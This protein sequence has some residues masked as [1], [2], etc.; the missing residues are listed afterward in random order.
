MCSL[1]LLHWFIL[2]L[3]VNIQATHATRSNTRIEQFF[4]FCS[5]I[6]KFV[7][8]MNIIFFSQ[9]QNIFLQHTL[10]SIDNATQWESG[11]SYM[12]CSSVHQFS[13]VRSKHL[14]P[15]SSACMSKLVSVLW[16][17]FSKNCSLP[18][19]CRL[20]ITIGPVPSPKN[21]RWYAS[22]T[23]EKAEIQSIQTRTY[24][25]SGTRAER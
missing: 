13:P 3:A 8:S 22:P 4:Y 5:S 12:R 24:K 19:H 16:V 7:L 21:A 23:G 11:L 25:Y 18:T 15:A 2:F 17:Q 6:H 20:S 10:I 9:E 1:E 14:T